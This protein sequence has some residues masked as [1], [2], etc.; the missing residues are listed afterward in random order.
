[1]LV[2]VD[3]LEG[4]WGAL[5][6]ALALDE[7]QLAVRD[8]GVV[9]ARLARVQSGGVLALPAG[10][11]VWR[12]DIRERGTLENLLLAPYADAGGELG[13]G[14]VRVAMRAVGLNFR[15]VLIALDMYP[16]EAALGGEGAGV[17]VEVGPGVEDL[18]VGD[19]V[20]GMFIDGFASV[21]VTDRRLIA[22]IPEG[23]SFS[24]AAAVPIVFLTAFYGLVDLA[25]LGVGERVLV[26]AAAGGVG[27]AAVQLARCLGAEVFGTAS[28]GK[29]GVLEGLGLDEAHIASSRSLEF[30]DSFLE[31]SGG[32]GVDVVLNS[33]AGEFVDASLGLLPGGGRFIEIGKTD[34]RDAGVVAGECPG[35][36]Y[37]AFALMEAGPERI[38]EMLVEVLGLFE[39]GLLEALPLTVWDVRR[40][41]EAFRFVAQAQHVGKNVLTLPAS[42]DRGG[43]VLITGGTGELGGLLA[44]HLV[45][46]YGVGRLLLASRGGRDARGALELEAELVGLGAVVSVVACD[47]GDRGELR[48][49]VESVPVEFPLR[50]VVHAAGV[51]DDGVIGSLTPERVDRVFAPKVDAAWYLHEL[52]EHLDLSAFVLFSSAAGAFGG[53]GQGNYAAANAFLDGLACHRRARG[54]PGS[55]IAW[56][57]WANA[58]AMTGHLEGSDHARLGRSGIGALSVEEGLG[59]FD[60]ALRVDEA[61]AVAMRLDTAMLRAIASTGAVPPLLR[62]LARAPSR[63]AGGAGGESLARSLAGVAEGD[64][65]RVTLDLVRAQAAVVL[66]HDSPQA[67]DAQRAFKDLGF[68]SLTAVELR[69]RLGHVS[70]LQL[71]ATLVFDYPTPLA[72]AQYLVKEV[73]GSGSHARVAVRSQ[74][75]DEPIAIV[76]VGCRYPGGIDSAEGLWELVAGAGDAISAFPTDRGW[77][78]ERLFDAD[79]DSSGTSYVSEGGFVKDAG[80]FDPGFFGISPREAVAM[81]PQQRLLLEVAWE[82]FEDAGIVPRSLRGSLTGVFAGIS[83]QDYGVSLQGPVPS[84]LEGY[85]GT[86]SVGSVISGRVA[87]TF[88]LEGPAVTI[89]TA[90]SSSLVA[91]HLACQALRSGEC[92]LALAAGVTVLASPGAFIAF[93]RQ[94]G[95]A[96]DGRCKAFAAAADGTGLAEGVG[97]VLLERLSVAQRAGHRVLAVVRGSAVNQDGASNGLSAP[98]GPSQQR[99]I[100]QALA[101]A[102]LSAGEV[103]AVEAHGTGT[104]LGD[105]IEAQAL[106]ATYGRGREEANPLWLGSIKSNIGHTQA[107]AGMAGVIKMAMAMRHSVLPKT[108]HIDEPSKNIDWTAGAVSLLTEPQ[109]WQANGHPRRAGV[110]S[111]GISGTNAHVILEE[112][113]KP[114][115][116]TNNTQNNPHDGLPSSENSTPENTPG[117]SGVGIL[118][119][120]VLG[121]DAHARKSAAGER[122]TKEGVGEGVID[123]EDA[124]GEELVAGGVVPWV[125]SGR[126][127]GGLRAQAGRL[128]EFAEARSDLDV[129]DLAF[130]LATSRA[131]FEYRA[132]VLGEDRPGLLDGLGA[133]AGGEPSVGVIAGATGTVDGAGGRVAFMFA[134]QGSQW[135][136]MALALLDSSPV[137]ATHLA[138]CADALAPYV[139][140]SLEDVLRGAPDAPGLDRVDVVQPALFAVMV[141]LAEL[142]RAC[143]VQPAVVVGHSQGEIAAAHI[144]G[145]LTLPDAAQLVTL[146]SRALVGLMGRGGMV[147]VALG[148]GELG[149]WLER[150]DGVSLAAVNGPSSVVVSGERGALDGLLAELVEGGVRAREIPVGYASHSA[151]V[152]EIRGE[153]LEACAGVVAVSGGVPFFSTVTGGLLDTAGLDGEYWYRNLRGTVQFEGAVRS[154]VADGHRAFVEL[155]PHPVLTMAVQEV[156]DEVLPGVENVLVS[157]SLRRGEGGQE[158]F[159]RSLGEAWVHGVEVDWAALFKGTSAARVALPSYAFQRERYW[160]QSA[161]GVGDVASAGLGAADHPLLG[162]AVALAGGEGWLFTGRLSLET[163][164]W[165]ADHAFM[166]TVLLAGTAFVEL[167]LRAGSEVGCERVQE[168]VLEAPLVFPERGSVQIQVAVG[169]PDESAR[170][171]VGIYSRLEGATGE[172]LLEE[173]QAWVRHASGTLISGEATQEAQAALRGD[174]EVALREE[175]AVF[176]DGEWPPPGAQAVDVDGLYDRLAEYGYEY[177]PVFQGLEALWREGENVFAEVSLPEGER[178]QAQQFALHPA[179]LDAALH[180]VAASLFGVQATAADGVGARLPFSWGGVTL[181]AAGASRLRVRL[182]PLGSDAVSLVVADE[183]GGL[184]ARVD[185]LVLRPASAE[186]LRGIHRTHQDSLYRLDWVPVAATPVPSDL[187]GQWAV[188][189]AEGSPFTDGICAAHSD[190]VLYT[191]LD[192]LS[193]ALDDGA[194]VPN[195]VLVDCTLNEAS[196]DGDNQAAGEDGTQAAVGEDDVQAAVGEG[197]SVHGAVGGVPGIAGAETHRVL[198]LLQGWLGDE[199]FVGCRLVLVTCGAV[200][201]SSREGV[202][203]LGAAPVWGL[204]RSAQSENP[205]RFVLVDV[206]GLEGSWGALPGALAL[207][208]PQLAVRD[209]GVVAA[210]LARVQSGGVLALPAGDGVWRLD[211]RERGT[212]ENLL[213]A[214]YADAGGELGEGQVRVAMRAVGLNFRDVLI[215]LDMYPGEAALGGEGAGVV[216]EVGPGVEDLVVG[217]RVMGMFIDGFASVA[218]TDRRL[219]ARIPEGWSFSE[220]AAVPIVFLTAF[221]GLVDL[222]GLGVGERVLVHAAA[223]GVGMAAVQLARCLGAEVFGTASPGK[224]GV[225]EGLGLD[226]A[227]IASSRSLEFRDSFLE[228]SGGRGVDVVLNSLAGEFVDASLGLLPG[229]GRFIEIGKTDVRDAGVVA[230][231]CPGVDYRAFALMEAG[232]ER[233]QEMLVEVLGLFERGLLEALPLTVWDVRRAPEAFRFVA[234][235]QHVGKNVLTLPASVDRGGTVLITGGTGELG[236]LLARHLVSEYGV[237]RLLLASRGG[238]DARGALELEAELVGLGAVVSVVACDVGDRGELRELVESVPVEFPLRMV[239]H[240][241]GVLDDG[242]IGSLTPERVDRVFAP[243]VDAAWY[244]HEL[245]EHLDL[246]AFV[247]FSSAAGA[248]GGPG[249]GNYAAANA[250]LD[251]LACHRRARGLP[252]SSIAWGLWANASAMT[253]HLEGSDHARLGRSGIGALSVE[254][255]LGLFD[256]ALRV[257]EALAVAMRLD[258]AM[259]RAIASTGAVPPLLRG[260]ARA[261]SRRA[262]GAGGESLARSLAGVAEGDRERV[263]LDLVRA[264]AAVVLGHDSPQAIDAQRA[265]KDLGFDSLTAVELR[266]RLGHVSGLQLPA[267]LVFDYPTPFA[268]A[269][270]LLETLARDGIGSALSVDA[271]LDRLELALSSIAAED[272][273]RTEVAERLQVFLTRLRDASLSGDG[274]AVATKIHSATAAEVLDFID[275]EL[276]S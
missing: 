71:P 70:G 118:G 93:S 153:L 129:G 183:S 40:A 221:Y 163:H 168:L 74:G 182:T 141:S 119:N 266:N 18:V 136:G 248:F 184:V 120:G 157:G 139:D 216:V 274:E 214:P 113:P 158:R 198:G 61:L 194:P 238:R 227:H 137:F 143:G 267:T 179:L 246:S 5:P 268:L 125:L 269:Q 172:G 45:S 87:Y 150:W 104:V 242:V 207:D 22:R 103:D 211:I 247:L 262:G 231:E 72:L 180:A 276:G 195:V 257:D 109:P 11:G 273:K 265:F 159:V 67:I 185:S 255:G 16:G 166:G 78:L 121:D 251:G 133:L 54:L 43:T 164:P 89:D 116:T 196:R 84:D 107:A 3:G 152:E 58:S 131:S 86:G 160:I 4:S 99:V 270:Y 49:L 161:W 226:E 6:G 55:S 21:A 188:L 149:S 177:G 115:T 108:L 253:G 34:V 106:L 65:E 79:P 130:S 62:G 117:H 261:P 51:L 73:A 229:G 52:T 46:E 14:Q 259:L 189:G 210:R 90:C 201:V 272:A 23:W 220:A 199:R 176:A 245:T 187:T 197:D 191:D 193:H 186:Q 27:M 56:G 97:V 215:A 1:V 135:P 111:F 170:R 80:D 213:L 64:R 200:G 145:G 24:E 57:L 110:S 126:G 142:W 140:W 47:V 122:A 81:D 250:F 33:L 42:V 256:E 112:P 241:A 66:G 50:M 63:R 91:L 223:G 234:Q 15:D 37:R 174:A 75:T 35:V 8:G 271:E 124:A 88:G 218:V 96:L 69:N 128:R 29:W 156:V 94:R 235:A 95:L 224:W 48:E 165:L 263:T 10:D 20:M 154:L 39:R 44:R 38:Q 254:E 181:H 205:G 167:A 249:Q 230:G 12:L 7:P 32:R 132:V 60:E 275:K 25:G 114:T 17:V 9:A 190:T 171:T 212:L 173:Q 233:I 100:S 202:L 162:A 252:G 175:T 239:V 134:G 209:G 147:S 192:L 169:E 151:M 217:D 148:V 92:S 83:S 228:A 19:R 85:M 219:I 222:A 127:L 204:V 258:T 225:L 41:P 240:A 244:L 155:S 203:G 53:P 2:D 123:G 105:P 232:P 264:Q 178:S 138:R 68:D 146:R 36:D 98:N 101:N 77:D 59:L 144:A 236:G 243:K 30:R 260:L 76:G 26:H 206:D 28:P 237:G 13:E 82:A 31:A 208:E 102:G